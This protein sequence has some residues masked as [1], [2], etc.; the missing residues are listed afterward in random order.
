M[1]VQIPRDW[2]LLHICIVQVCLSCVFL[3]SGNKGHFTNWNDL[4]KGLPERERT[5]IMEARGSHTG[6]PHMAL[7]CLSHNFSSLILWSTFKNIK[8]ANKNVKFQCPWKREWSYEAHI[9]AWQ[10]V[11]GVATVLPSVAR[12]DNFPHSPPCLNT[13]QNRDRV[14]AAICWLTLGLL[15]VF[16][17]PLLALQA[18]ETQL[19]AQSWWQLLLT[20]KAISCMLTFTIC[21][22]VRVGLLCPFP[23]WRDQGSKL[24]I[25]HG[26]T[27]Q[28]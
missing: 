13:S 1:C 2:S 5:G 4:P 18:L 16:P 24:S 20:V 26:I 27:Q 21:G 9:T 8:I 17:S 22:E 15:H 28:I 25:L 23:R 6:S 7:F 10:K 3:L 11:A 19:F 14:A 12:L